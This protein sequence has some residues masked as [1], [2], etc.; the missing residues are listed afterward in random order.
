MQQ[1]NNVFYDTVLQK[2]L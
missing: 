1:T 2:T